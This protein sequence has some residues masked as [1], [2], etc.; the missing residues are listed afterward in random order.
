MRRMRLSLAATLTASLVLAGC[1]G[2]DEGKKEEKDSGTGE[3][4][5]PATWPLTGLPVADGESAETD[6]PVF[7]VKID[8]SADS[9]PQYGLSQADLVVEELVEGG[10]TRL[11]VLFQSELPTNVGPV[12]SMRLSDIGIVKP[13][14]GEL[15]TS[16]AAGPTLRG[17]DEAGVEYHGEDG[18]AVYREKS[19]VHDSLHNVVADLTELAK[20]SEDGEAERPADY[21]PWGDAFPGGQAAKDVDV[22][23]SGGRTA[24]WAFRDGGYHLENNYFDEGDEFV[25]DTVIVAT[26]EVTKAPY[27]GYQGA[28][29][30]VSHFAGEG[31]VV[32]FHDGEAVRG[33]WEK[34]GE[35]GELVLKT[36]K[37]ELE[38]PAGHTWIH[39]VPA[40]GSV[41]TEGG[42]TFR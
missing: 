35:G 40:A 12:R 32:V 17:L 18:T 7:A 29:V 10:I 22:K 21:L 33:T 1:G 8:N 19:S 3:T 11:A 28:I 41:V 13:V 4:A 16:G 9:A 34:D 38:I 26:V 42:V 14:D 20:R 31:P 24:Q 36:R 25:A 2:G 15:V 37:G 6:H 27:D 39:L 30:P 23:M 5:A